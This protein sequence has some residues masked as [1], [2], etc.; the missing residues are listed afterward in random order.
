MAARR[1]W[2]AGAA[3]LLCLLL[4]AAAVAGCG[5][6]SAPRAPESTASAPAADRTARVEDAVEEG[7]RPFPQSRYG[8]TDRELRAGTGYRHRAPA[9]LTDGFLGGASN[10]VSIEWRP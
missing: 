8:D 10:E 3:G 4:L 1:P 9:R 2:G 7:G 6:K 5:R